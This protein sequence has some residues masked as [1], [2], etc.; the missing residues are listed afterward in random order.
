MRE[1]YFKNEE[2]VALAARLEQLVVERTRELAIARDGAIA[3]SRAKSQFLANMSHELR[4]QLNAIL[5]YSEMLCD[6]A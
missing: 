3:A 6:E 5:G 4:T 1:V 2:L